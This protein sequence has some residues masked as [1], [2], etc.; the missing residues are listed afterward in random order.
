[1]T[2]TLTVELLISVDGWAGSDDLPGYFGYMGPEVGAWIADE[3]AVPHVALMGRKTYEV[4]SDLPDEAKD[5]E[6]EKMTRQETVVF[7]R[8]LTVVDWPNARVADDL[9]TA[10]TD[11][12]ATSERPL[13]TIGSPSSVCQLL[14]AGLVDRLRLVTFPLFAGPHGREWAYTGIAATDLD[15]V[16]HHILDGRVMVAE[17]HPTGRPIPQT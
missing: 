11:L 16:E 2:S 5:E 1:M 8:T 7:S 15:L 17:Y 13:R 12:K 6:W 10:T 14:S 9:V 3:L 4:L